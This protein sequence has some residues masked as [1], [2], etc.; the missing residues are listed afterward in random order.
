M[1]RE[2]GRVIAPEDKETASRKRGAVMSKDKM[3]TVTAVVI[4][5]AVSA[6]TTTQLHRTR[7]ACWQ[8]V[9]G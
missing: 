3:S 4:V 2:D 6:F 5:I 7:G 8:Q 1:I 9:N